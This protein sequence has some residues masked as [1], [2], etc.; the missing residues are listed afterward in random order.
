[1][2]NYKNHSHVTS[3][4]VPGTRLYAVGGYCT[5]IDKVLK[6]VECY[7]T[8]TGRWVMD[9]EDLPWRARWIAAVAVPQYMTSE[10]AE[11]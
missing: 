1:M 7:D 9:L 3:V 8:R 10:D 5:G 11:A 4:F 6:S 2:F